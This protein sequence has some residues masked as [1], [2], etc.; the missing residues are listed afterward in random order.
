MCAENSWQF[1]AWELYDR[2]YSHMLNLHAVPLEKISQDGSQQMASPGVTS[3]PS[4][5]E[6]RDLGLLISWVLEYLSSSGTLPSR[7][8]LHSFAQ[9]LEIGPVGSIITP[10]CL[11]QLVSWL[12]LIPSGDEDMASRIVADMMQAEEQPATSQNMLR[13]IIPASDSGESMTEFGARLQRNRTSSPDLVPHG[14]RSSTGAGKKPAKKKRRASANGAK[15]KKKT[16]K[17]S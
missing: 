6:T 1:N 4:P 10:L 13:R 7:D 12:I 16:A 5:G 14:K 8:Q 3:L 11:V 2:V 9:S 17:T 15:S